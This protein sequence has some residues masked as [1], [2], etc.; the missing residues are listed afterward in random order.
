MNA[1]RLQRWLAACGVASRRA[2][3]RYITD[4][5]VTVNGRVV[6]ELGTKV[7]PERD[8]VRVDGERAR[9]SQRRIYVALNKPSGV[10][11][12]ASDPAGRPRAIDLVQVPARLF[13]VGR[14]DAESEGLLLLT[15]D[16]DFAQRVTHPR[17]EVPKVYRVVVKGEP[18]PDALAKLREGVWLAE[19]KAAPAEIRIL[20]QTRQL[21]TLALT[22]REGKNR[23]VRRLL[24][25]VE[26]AVKRLMRVR[27]GP[28]ILGTLKRGQWRTL[29]E[30]EVRAL[31]EGPRGSGPGASGHVPA[32]RPD[33][34]P[35]NRRRLTAAS[36][37]ARDD[38]RRRPGRSPAGRSRPPRPARR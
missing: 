7:D 14:L 28:V 10:V 5:R 22:L 26:L 25:R 23:E 15:N 33:H 12:T 2:S 24:A 6:T 35:G 21:T 34:A 16:G 4:G 8:E 31:L 9:A 17:Y 30:F 11:C 36:R 37:P 1:M 38:R 32:G 18:A 13:P 20:R 19:G 3:E 29:T 27:I